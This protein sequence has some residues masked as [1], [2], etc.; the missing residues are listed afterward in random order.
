[1]KNKQLDQEKNGIT[2]ICCAFTVGF[3]SGKEVINN[4]RHF[5]I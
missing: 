3:M 1:M 4:K 2:L 5:C